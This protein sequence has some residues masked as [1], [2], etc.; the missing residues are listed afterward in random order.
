MLNEV[1]LEPVD[2][3]GWGDQTPELIR[4]AVEFVVP[5]ESTYWS[6]PLEKGE[7]ET[8]EDRALRWLFLVCVS[9][10]SCKLLVIR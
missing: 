3:S 9:L 6:K 7:T 10:E 4:G 5:K 2:M 1:L 8:L